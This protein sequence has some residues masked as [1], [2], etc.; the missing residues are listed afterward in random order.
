MEQY[1]QGV[2]F[3]ARVEGGQRLAY[4]GDKAQNSERVHKCEDTFFVIHQ[5]ILHKIFYYSIL[6]FTFN[7]E[8]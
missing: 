8:Y 6:Q 1:L 4:V 2:M 7:F 5:N 3:R